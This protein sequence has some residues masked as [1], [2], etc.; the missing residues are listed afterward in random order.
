M[1]SPSSSPL[2]TPEAL[3]ETVILYVG[4]K[5]KKYIVHK[6]ILCDQSEFFNAGFNNGF[7]EA[8]DGEMYLPE[9]D[10][11]TFAD[12]IEYFYRGTLP[13]TDKTTTR[14]VQ[15][16]Y[17][18]A[19]KICMPLLM[20]KLMDA[21]M[22]AH[23]EKNNVGFD[24]GRTQSI[25]ENTHSTSKL[26]L[27]AA[28]TLAFNIHFDFNNTVDFGTYLPLSKTCPEVFTDVFRIIYVH[29]LSLIN[30]SGPLDG[31]KD[32]FGPCG[33]HVHSS[34]GVCYKKARRS[35]KLDFGKLEFK[36]L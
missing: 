24:V 35:M 32:A 16:L 27:Y 9:D 13:Y 11:A 22:E 36:K 18:P 10:P 7:K 23:A 15:E 20:D 21:I 25:Y 26:R 33:F 5:R 31:V 8:T 1:S 6:K 29:R 4:S 28:A 3:N 34:D 12:L 14:P 17:C 30:F 2:M 19:E